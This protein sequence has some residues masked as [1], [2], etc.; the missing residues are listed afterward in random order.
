MS[1][2]LGRV[3]GQPFDGEPIGA[4]GKCGGGGLAYV[5]RPIVEH[6]DDRLDRP[7][8]KHNVMIHTQSAG[9]RI[10]ELSGRNK[11]DPGKVVSIEGEVIG[12]AYDFAGSGHYDVDKVIQTKARADHSLPYLL[13]V[14]LIDGDVTPAPS[15]ADKALCGEIKDGVRSLEK[16]PAARVAGGFGFPWP[17]Q[18]ARA[19]CRGAA[20]GRFHPFATRSTNGRFLRIPAVH[21]VVFWRSPQLG[22]SSLLKV[23]PR[24]G[25]NH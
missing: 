25:T 13:A 19:S 10:V 18:A 17:T 20:L 3:V 16:I 12:I 2:E 15:R 8:K 7:I 21:C 23:G 1:V 5:D 6:D 24:A 11:L 14:T 4:G 9:H 22:G